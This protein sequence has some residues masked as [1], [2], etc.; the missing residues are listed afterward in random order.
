[1]HKNAIVLKLPESFR[2]QMRQLLGNYAD[3]FEQSL[4]TPPPVSVRI[5]THY[6]PSASHAYENMLP[7]PWCADGRYL[8]QR[9]VFTLDPLFHAGVYY[10]QEA[11]SMYLQQVVNQILKETNVPQTVLDLCA[12]PGG[13]STHMASLLPSGSLL[14]TNEIIRSRA[15]ILHENI[16]KWGA[17]NCV[18]CN[19]DPR[20]FS[21]LTNF[22]DIILVDAPCSGE[23]MF[24][25]DEKAIDEWSEANVKL[26]AERQ[27]RIL[28]DVWAALKPNGYLIY[29]TCTY[30][31]HENEENVRWIM[32]ELGAISIDINSLNAKE[33]GVSP[34][35]DTEVYAARF[36]PHK[37]QGE[38]LFMALLQK[39]NKAEVQHN[40]VRNSKNNDQPLNK[41]FTYVKNWLNNANQFTFIQRVNF[42]QALP[43]NHINKIDALRQHLKILS[44]GII[45]G[46][47]KGSTVIP[48]E[49]LALN[50]A[51]NQT[52]FTVWSVDDEVALNYLRRNAIIAPS[53]MPK[54]YL[55]LVY[56]KM[57]LGW[58]K[59]LGNRVNNLYPQEWRI[60]HL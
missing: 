9:D 18:V 35:F 4:Q 21:T 32:N 6:K 24:R 46:E 13:K 29:S 59:N 42:I 1:M 50:A 2:S 30:N 5:N 54:G 31:L 52:Q 27:R 55:L 7:I 48:N 8:P 28:A 45:L 40:K 39:H 60:R 44:A 14:V 20:D 49:A 57:P 19:N 38:G 25:K 47:I 26:C 23:G 17:P 15:N 43:N 34:S 33:W 56:K 51:I 16:T 36:F 12:A 37:T 3:A 22:F 58:V 53:D 11:S 41:S 10:V